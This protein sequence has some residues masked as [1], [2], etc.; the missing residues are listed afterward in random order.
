[1][2]EASSEVRDGQT[3]Q[4]LS[5]PSSIQVASGWLALKASRG[6]QMMRSSPARKTSNGCR[7]SKARSYYLR[8]RRQRVSPDRRRWQ[9]GRPAC[10]GRR[11]LAIQIS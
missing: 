4:A 3:T 8:L 7:A 9:R 2:E 1:M 6:C 5:F 10:V 11:P